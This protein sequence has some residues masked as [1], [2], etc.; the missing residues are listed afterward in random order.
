MSEVSFP[1]LKST[2]RSSVV[3]LP[4]ILVLRVPLN[5]GGGPLGAECMEP[6]S[7]RGRR[8]RTRR[9]RS[10]CNQLYPFR[11]AG[12][13]D[14]AIERNCARRTRETGNFTMQIQLPRP[15]LFSVSLVA[16]VVDDGGGIVAA[17][18]NLNSTGR[19]CHITDPL[20][21]LPL[22]SRPDSYQRL[23]DSVRCRLAAFFCTGLLRKL[24]RTSQLSFLPFFSSTLISSA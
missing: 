6:L 15:G 18:K 17:A 16:V 3:T 24:L 12:S 5:R 8:W 9:R 13:S 14:G 2:L 19:V 7:D 23:F 10:F 22:P 1:Q 11:R 4:K 20:P 21:S